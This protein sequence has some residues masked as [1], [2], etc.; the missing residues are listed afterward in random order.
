[1]FYT[2]K[3]WSKYLPEVGEVIKEIKLCRQIPNI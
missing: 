2:N 1:M 3:N